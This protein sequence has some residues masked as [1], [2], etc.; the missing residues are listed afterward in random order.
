MLTDGDEVSV[1]DTEDGAVGDPNAVDIDAWS[2]ILY[3]LDKDPVVIAEN[4]ATPAD[5][6]AVLHKNFD[7]MFWG[8]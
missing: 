1:S 6:L 7:G 5:V 8:G 3:M 2:V 4:V